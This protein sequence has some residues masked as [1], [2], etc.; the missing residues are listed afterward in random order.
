MSGVHLLGGYRTDFAR[1]ATRE[2]LELVDLL[3]E[4][5]LG[6]CEAASV[7]PE[8]LQVGHV[9]NFVAELY[10]GQGHL[11]GLLVEA[12]PALSG[13][14]CSRHEAACA[15]GSMAVLA[16]M[17]DLESGRY[18][19]ALVA[20][21]ELMRALPAFESQGK[22]AAA[23]WVPRETAGLTYP[24]AE[25]FDRLLDE[26][27]RR[28]G[29]ARAG[30][31]SA[32]S[33]A[34][35]SELSRQAFAAARRSPFAQTRGWTFSDEAFGPDDA[36]NPVVAGRIRRQDCSQ[37]TDGAAAVVLASSRY[38][39]SWR[40]RTG[41]SP[42]TVARLAGWGHRTSRMALADKLADSASSEYVFPDVRRAI[43]DACARAS[44]AGASAMDV[45]ELHD[46]FT[47]TAFMILDHLGLVPPGHAG[48]LI[49][50]GAVFAGGRWPINPGGGLVGGGHPVGATGVRMVLDAALQV[51]GAAGPIQVEGASRA[52]TV[53]LGGSA[54]TTACF[55]LERGDA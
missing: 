4:A 24:W 14:P 11:G 27:D 38:L 36:S 13:M 22:L 28:H 51:T 12:H 10:S 15:S 9:G 54:T 16:A 39:E 41:R 33:R 55:V 8:E 35:L 30:E 2:R 40:A 19:V 31:G 20:G 32:P 29:P 34:Q 23:A 18:D 50:E 26:Y 49:D 6:A 1:N 48:R 45:I 25:L 44:V 37:L 7:G 43:V 3:R 47:P 21:V 53:N 42:A 46:C 5:T 17:A 52:L